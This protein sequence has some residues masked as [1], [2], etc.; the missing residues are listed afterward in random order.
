MAEQHNIESVLIEKRVFAPPAD[1]A[2]QA[3]LKAAELAAL[4]NRRGR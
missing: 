1:F 3:R 2:A 4:K